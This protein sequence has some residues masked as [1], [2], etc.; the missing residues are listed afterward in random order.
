M[1][2]LLNTELQR[3]RTTFSVLCAFAPL[4]SDLIKIISIIFLCLLCCFSVFSQEEKIYTTNKSTLYGIGATS[5]LDT[6]LS[7]LI[8]TGTEFRISNEN[9]RLSG[10]LNGKLSSQKRLDF[11][12]SQTKNPAETGTEL[13]GFFEWNWGYHYRFPITNDLKLLAGGLMYASAGVIYNTRNSNNPVS[14]KLGL[15]LD[16]SGM[17]LYNLKI[18][19]QPIT[20][21]A[22]VISP[23]IGAAFSPGYGQSYYDI[24]SLGN[25]DDVIK[26]SSFGNLLAC[27][28]II[29]ADIPLNKIIL[30]V[31][32]Q[33]TT[34]TSDFNNLDTKMY[35]NTFLIGFVSEV[36]TIKGRK[37]SVLKDSYQSAYY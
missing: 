8:Y 7:P 12:F 4:R 11:S 34:Y 23:F 9:N 21:R 36:L 17:A 13:S 35:S 29:S 18:K 27:K 24:F 5:I 37:S 6:Y 26:F 2:I 31:A 16:L 15:G 19:E 32:Y 30:R 1:K 25:Y 10:Y 33:N 28:T 3:H 14:A 20:L 22:Q